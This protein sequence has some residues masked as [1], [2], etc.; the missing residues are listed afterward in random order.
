MIPVDVVVEPL[1][2][3]NGQRNEL[4]DTKNFLKILRQ[5]IREPAVVGSEDSFFRVLRR[6]LE[7]VGVD[8]HYY[9]GVLVAQGSRPE[10]LMLSA[11]IDRHGLL[12]TG[13]NEFQYAAF[14]AG[15]KGELS[16]DS[17]SEQMLNT[18]ENRFQDQRVQAHQ[19]YTGA[20]IGQGTI[21]N[22]YICPER[23]NLIFE[24]DGLEHL[25]P[26]TP[27]AFLDRLRSDGGYISAQLDNVISAAMLIFLFRCG[28]QGTAL[29]TAQEESGRSWRHALSWFQRHQLTT[30]RLIALDTSPYHSREAADAQQV[31]LRRKDASAAFAGA[32]TQELAAR[33]EQLGIAYSYKDD[34]ID[35]QNQ[36]R[37]KPYSMGRTEIGRLI[38]AT[39]GAISGTTLQIPTTD[40]HTPNETASLSS[41]AAM[42]R[43]LKSYCVGT[44]T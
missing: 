9:Y 15:N 32:M 5:L 3:A 27:V 38:A 20:Y 34:Y 25:Q 26:G 29:F 11:H 19:P 6:E 42:L 43:L 7:E 18:I 33:C 22:S 24:V 14:V 37:T 4:T 2:V 17:V 30:Q 41:V 31:V 39:D 36:T 28:F 12:C 40:Y 13:P 23:H 35:A 8:V 16:G 1:V 10:S 44:A 21:T